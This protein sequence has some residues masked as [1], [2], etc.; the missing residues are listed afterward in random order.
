MKLEVMNSF[1]RNAMSNKIQLRYNRVSDVFETSPVIY[2]ILLLLRYSAKLL[3]L[4]CIHEVIL[5][6]L[7]RKATFIN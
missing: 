6:E 2:I 5:L 1:V 4:E 7:P 3:P